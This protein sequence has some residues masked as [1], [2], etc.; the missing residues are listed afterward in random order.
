MICNIVAFESGI[1]NYE[2][3]VIKFDTFAHLHIA[4]QS[5]KSFMSKNDTNENRVK[6]KRI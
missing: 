3:F 5:V 1:C 2:T 6:N 4:V